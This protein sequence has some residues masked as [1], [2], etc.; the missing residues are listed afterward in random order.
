M[1]P[2][3]KA[4]RRLPPSQTKV[5]NSPSS[6]QTEVLVRPA[7]QSPQAEASVSPPSQI[8]QDRS[9]VVY[10]LRVGEFYKIGKSITPEKRYAQLRIQLPQ[11]PELIHEIYTNNVD[12]VEKHWHK[13]FAEM[14]A[15]GE[16]F[17]LSDADV[18]E[19][20][21]CKRMEIHERDA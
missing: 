17:S 5:P 9:G 12:Y 2:L 11:K 19:F 6:P 18:A 16:W 21:R 4:L 14:R 13:R 20:T 10:L 1:M 15:N 7:T 3:A 8:E